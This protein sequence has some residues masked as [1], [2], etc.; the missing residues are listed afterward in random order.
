MSQFPHLQ[1]DEPGF[2]SLKIPFWLYYSKI[3]QWNTVPDFSLESINKGS[4]YTLDYQC[5]ST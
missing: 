2:K 5:Y 4:Y 3:S 1:K